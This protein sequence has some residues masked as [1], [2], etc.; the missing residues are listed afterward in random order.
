M[1]RLCGVQEKP[2]RESIGIPDY[3]GT[4][5]FARRDAQTDSML[6]TLGRDE[7]DVRP[8]SVVENQK[9]T[10]DIRGDAESPEVIV[11]GQMKNLE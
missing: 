8:V 4:M 7:G 5:K 9:R 10:L 6:T 3:S 1:W 2:S 11:Y